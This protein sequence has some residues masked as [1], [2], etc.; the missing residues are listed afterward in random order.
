MRSGPLRSTTVDNEDEAIA[1]LVKWTLPRVF[2]WLLK[3]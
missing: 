3:S 2:S 1:H